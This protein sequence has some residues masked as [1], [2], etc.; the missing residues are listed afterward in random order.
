[1]QNFS[2]PKVQAYEHLDTPM[3]PVDASINL[4]TNSPNDLDNKI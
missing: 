4:H 1:M 3:K 2:Q